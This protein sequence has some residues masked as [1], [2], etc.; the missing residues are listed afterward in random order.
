MSNTGTLEQLKDKY[1]LDKP[2]ILDIADSA[3]YADNADGA[4]GADDAENADDADNA[5]NADDADDAENA[6]NAD[7]AGLRWW[8]KEEDDSCSAST[9]TSQ[10]G[11]H[12]LSLIQII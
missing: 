9:R 5:D 2:Q 6:D 4:D 10:L 1:V 11:Q 7:G 8:E 12:Q 3:D